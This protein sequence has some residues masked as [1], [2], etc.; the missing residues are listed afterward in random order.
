MIKFFESDNGDLLDYDTL[1]VIRKKFKWHYRNITNGKEL[2]S[3]LRAGEYAWPGGYRLFFLT[4]DGAAI[5]F[6]AVRDNLPSVLD[7]IRTY[8][9]DGWRVIACCNT[10]HYD[11]DVFCDHSGDLLE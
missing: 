3:T 6:D 1:T 11:D 10:E 4:S 2:L 8:S 7:S 9:S 5:S